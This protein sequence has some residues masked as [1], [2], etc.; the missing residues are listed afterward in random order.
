[1][2]EA[3]VKRS[4]RRG[5]MGKA[6]GAAV[7]AL[8]GLGAFVAGG[9]LYPVPPAK[10]RPMFVRREREIEPGK[11]IELRHPNGRKVLLI[12]KPDGELMA[13]STVCTHLGCTAL[14]RPQK[15]D[16]HC[17]C[18]DGYFDADGRP[19]A[20]PPQRPLA[21]YAVEVRN[22]LVFVDFG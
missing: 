10:Q 19:V 13:I 9:F 18:H 5:F 4:S 6:M 15:Q 20:G 3:S 21:T 16:F 8:G 7:A 14:Y 17:P 22:G 1:M 11:P 12:R 2:G